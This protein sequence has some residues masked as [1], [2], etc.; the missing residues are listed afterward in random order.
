MFLLYYLSFFCY[1]YYYSHIYCIQYT[2]IIA[3]KKT[4]AVYAVYMY[5]CAMH[6]L[7][8]IVFPL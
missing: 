7:N 4:F 2:K 1:Y 8:I 3:G 6:A 5:I